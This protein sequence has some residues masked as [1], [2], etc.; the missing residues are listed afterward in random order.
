MTVALRD[1]RSPAWAMEAATAPAVV[2]LLHGYG[3]NEADLTGLA[4]PLKLAMPWASLRAPL[5]A[6]NGGAAWF[7][8]VTPGNPDSAPVAEATDAIWAWV[9]ENLD[10]STK[11]VPLGFSQGGLM[12]NQ[13]LRT[14][15]ERVLAP[16]VLGGFVQAASQPG[17]DAL[18]HSRP[19]LFWGRGAEDRVIGEPS[20]GRTRAYLPQHSTL[21]EKVYPGLA[22]G[23]SA[24]EIDDVHDFLAREVG[25]GAVSNE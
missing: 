5:E 14:R 10:P 23:I 24:Q 8:I 7:S 15:P 6:G 22:H 9:D 17:D 3:S 18:T 2:I 12:A 11:V 20:I 13:L 4:A 1:I 16:V 21:V 25:A 19:A